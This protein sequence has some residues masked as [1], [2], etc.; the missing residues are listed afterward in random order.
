MV[1]VARVAVLVVVPVLEVVRPCY[2]P[3]NI[4]C[5]DPNLSFECARSPVPP[6]ASNAPA[7]V[8]VMGTSSQ[9]CH[10]LEPK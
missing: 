4:A 2:F 9:T 6:V 8:G 5:Y 3:M 1:L 7:S 10:F